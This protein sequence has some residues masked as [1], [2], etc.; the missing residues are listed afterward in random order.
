MKLLGNQSWELVCNHLVF[1][2]KISLNVQH[3]EQIDP[4]HRHPNV[5]VLF[6]ASGKSNSK[7]E[8]TSWVFLVPSA[9]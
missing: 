8:R 1:V 2:S 5:L 6:R 7:M 3:L 9:S 4:A